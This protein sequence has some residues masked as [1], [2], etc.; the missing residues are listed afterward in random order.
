[1]SK[2]T[3]Q[4]ILFKEISGKPL[5]VDFDGGAVTSNSGLLFLRE[6]E[7][8]FNLIGRVAG[9]LRDGRHSSYVKHQL[10]ELMKQR[11]FQII[12]GHE[13]GNDCD[14]LR[15]DP[16]LKMACERLPI[17]GQALASQPTMCRFENAFSR[18]DLYRIAKALLDVFI[19]SYDQAP[20]AIIIDFDDT[21]DATH[22]AQQLSFFN[23][24]HDTYCYLPLHVYEGRSGKLITTILRP[25]KRPSGREI[26]AILKRL[27]KQIRAQWPEVGIIFRGD[28]YYSTPE[29]FD[30]CDAHNIEY[31]LGLTPRKPMLQKARALIAQAQELYDSKAETIKL[32][33]QFQYQ[34]ASWS[35]PQ[36]VIVKAEHNPKGAN[37][38]FIVTSLENSRSKFI[39]QKI[40]A[41]RG[42]VELMIKEHKTHL[43]SD[44]TSCSTFMANQF[45]VFLHSMAYILLHTFRERHLAG[46]EFA[47][48]QFNTIQNKILKVGARIKQLATKIKISLPS[49]FPS[50]NQYTTIW[51]S[52]CPNMAVT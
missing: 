24:Y 40:Y 23:A 27:V 14:T 5:E 12:A 49:S 33:G 15:D 3:N 38:R 52:C 35:K 6:L 1:L 29:V 13:D 41:D 7:S 45:R 46:T 30:F 11:V 43:L 39:Y 8:R 36:R 4:L 48:A 47:K 31:M 18:T 16:V 32:F 21:A 26:V 37:T 22:G 44:R 9:V 17:T 34:A 20:E 19:D 51:Q 2:D 10:V 28:S 50:K 42:R 25:G